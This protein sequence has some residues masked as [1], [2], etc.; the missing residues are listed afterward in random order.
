MYELVKC[1]ESS[2]WNT[3]IKES[4]QF[5]VFSRLEFLESCAVISDKWF[6]YKNN[7]IVLAALIVEPNN[8]LFKAPY[9]YSAYQGIYFF[10]NHSEVKRS[11][12]ALNELLNALSGE[13]KNISFSLHFSIRDIRAFQWFNYHSIECAKYEINILYT[14]IVDIIKYGN[15]EEYFKKIR[16]SRLQEYKKAQSKNMKFITS[17]DTELFMNLYIKTFQRQGI[18]IKE[19][20]LYK[21]QN[22]VNTALESEYGNIFLCL[23]EKNM[24]VSASV[25]LYDNNYAYY[26]FGATEPNYRNSGASAFLMLNVFNYFNSIGLH[27]FDMVGVNSPQRGDY[28]MS[29]DAELV[30]YYNLS[31]NQ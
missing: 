31:I 4:Q 3:V 6:L 23:D 5:S 26:L 14:G 13:Y 19:E 25:F 12:D 17:A 20:N 2:Q 27:K 30:P 7:K 18:S 28:K 8:P 24:A 21:V 16:K 11:L 15:I 9:P 1:T 22:I 29:Y 10:D